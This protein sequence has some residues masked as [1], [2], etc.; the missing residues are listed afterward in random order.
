VLLV[1]KDIN[2][3]SLSAGAF[4]SGLDAALRLVVLVA[5]VTHVVAR[6]AGSAAT[7]T[8]QIAGTLKTSEAS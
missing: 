2:L 1:P 3:L 6:P 7:E 8:W 4:S 5:A